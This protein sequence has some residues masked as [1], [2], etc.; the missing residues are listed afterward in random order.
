MKKDERLT[1]NNE[2]AEGGRFAQ[3]V[4]R[5]ALVQTLVLL[6]NV[7]FETNETHLRFSG[8]RLNLL[9]DT[10]NRQG[11]LVSVEGQSDPT[12]LDD[13]SLL[14]QPDDLK[15]LVTKDM[16]ERRNVVMVE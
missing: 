16:V 4:P 5:S 12:R 7:N 10:L 2:S 14:F 8:P 6:Q 3:L 13:R 1:L 11:A 15:W 9:A